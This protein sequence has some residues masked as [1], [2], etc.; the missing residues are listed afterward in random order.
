MILQNQKNET[1][2]HSNNDTGLMARTILSRLYCLYHYSKL[3][4]HK[5]TKYHAWIL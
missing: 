3:C 2:L 4:T 1:Q 5:S